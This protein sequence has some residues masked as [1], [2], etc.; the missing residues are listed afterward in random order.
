[1]A[2][3]KKYQDANVLEAARKRI[4][5]IFDLFDTVVVQFSGGK[6]SLVVLHL[7]WQEAQRRGHKK[8]RVC[9]RDEELIPDNVIDFVAEY[10]EKPWVEMQWLV[11][12]MLNQKYILGQH[13]NYVQ[14]DQ[15][16]KREWIRQPP[17]FARTVKMPIG[18]VLSQHSMDEL[19]AEPYK[20]SIAFLTGIRAAESLVR[21]RASVNK[22]NENYI[23]A[24]GSKRVRLCKPIYD[25]QENDVFKFFYDEQIRYCGIYDE[26]FTAN[27]PLRVSTPLHPAAAKKLGTLKATSPKFYNR[28]L[29][30]FPEIAVQERYYAEYDAH[31]VI[32]RFASKGWAGCADYINTYVQKGEARKR[33]MQRLHEFKV[34]SKRDKMAY[35]PYWLM[36]NITKGVIKRVIQGDFLGSTHE[37]FK[38]SLASQ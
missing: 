33:A 4:S 5:H 1:M 6:D 8:L 36:E 11:V 20:G 17:S 29:D 32:E 38:A 18:K 12:P 7:A 3:F 16:G 10:H 30:V 27:T 15:S 24:C 21:F 31:G 9:F 28:L 26:Q 34:M 19:M 25:W 37:K 14:W 13:M 2:R 22:L 35:N 23:N